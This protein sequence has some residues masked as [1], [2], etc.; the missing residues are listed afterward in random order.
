MPQPSTTAFTLIEIL[1]VISIIAVLAGMLL[2]AI[3]LM[4]NKARVADARQMVRE[5][6]LA[7]ETYRAE[8]ARKRYPPEADPSGTDPALWVLRTGVTAGSGNV[9]ELLM[10]RKLLQ[11]RSGALKEGV[12]VDPWGCAYRY[13]LRRPSQAGDWAG[14]TTTA[15]DWNWDAARSRVREWN[16]R[17]PATQAPF[18]YVWSYGPD[19]EQ[20]PIT[21]WIYHVPSR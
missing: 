9:L 12:L 15:T 17:N 11:L 6:T 5:L 10:D 8:D 7:M 16:D 18:P 3:G 4:R 19:G 14:P 13:T 1:I 20:A 21:G 2:P